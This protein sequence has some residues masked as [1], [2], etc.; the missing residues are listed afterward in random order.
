MTL[1]VVW[2]QSRLEGSRFV[3]LLGMSF[4]FEF[5]CLNFADLSLGSWGFVD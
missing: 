3:V 4:C 2:W 5:D 1:T